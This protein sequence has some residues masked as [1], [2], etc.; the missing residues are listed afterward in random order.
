LTHTAAFKSLLD[1]GPRQPESERNRSKRADGQ[2][3]EAMSEQM[4]EGR[5]A[6]CL[7]DMPR[8]LREH[9]VNFAADGITLIFQEP[10]PADIKTRSATY[11]HE[12][13]LR[14]KKDS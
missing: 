11:V 13:L 2:M 1:E 14:N 12:W 3:E 8:A 4:D 10:T 6:Q 5:R 7:A 9:V